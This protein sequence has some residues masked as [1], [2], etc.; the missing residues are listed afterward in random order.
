MLRSVKVEYTISDV[1]KDIPEKSP[2][3]FQRPK[4]A[5]STSKKKNSA[6]DPGYSLPKNNQ[7]SPKAS[8]WD[9]PDVRKTSPILVPANLVRPA[10]SNI[11]LPVNRRINPTNRV[12]QPPYS[13][14]CSTVNLDR[15][16]LLM[17]MDCE[18]VKYRMRHYKTN[19]PAHMPEYQG[20]NQS[21]T[22][23]DNK[24]KGLVSRLR[25]TPNTS[26]KILNHSLPFHPYLKETEGIHDKRWS[27]ATNP[28][29]E[30]EILKPQISCLNKSREAFENYMSV[31]TPK[32][33]VSILKDLSQIP[34]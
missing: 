3:R 10:S 21:N 8:H 17:E 5:E 6:I 23:Y 22:R 14:D 18:I 28:E 4:T 33:H 19:Q 29:E 15:D 30:N 1:A 25:N 20:H 27:I 13:F 16:L 7:T 32:E 31:S 24:Q 11:A 34:D 2:R 26:G 9:H 12:F